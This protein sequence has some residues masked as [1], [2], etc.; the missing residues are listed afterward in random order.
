MELFCLCTAAFLLIGLIRITGGQIS[1]YSALIFLLIALGV[2]GIRFMP[3]TVIKGQSR[4]MSW[5]KSTV[6]GF[7]DLRRQQAL[8]V[9]LMVNSYIQLILLGLIIYF[10][11]LSL[12]LVVNYLDGLLLG[13]VTSVSKYHF[14]LPGQLG[15]REMFIAFVTKIIQGSFNDGV[16]VAV[17][18]RVISG[19]A[20][21]VLGNIFSLMILRKIAD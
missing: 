7:D 5:L 12:G 1:G 9:R 2:I 19:V 11:F 16:I 10:T 14:L 18:D 6:A 13:V 3:L 8:I 15:L 4:I 17:T 21:I 20:T